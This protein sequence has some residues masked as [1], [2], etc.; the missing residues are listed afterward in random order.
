MQKVTDK[1]LDNKFKQAFDKMEINPSKDLFAKIGEDIH[2]KKNKRISFYVAAASIAVI[3]AIV[4]IGEMQST[5]LDVTTK[6]T[7]NLTQKGNKVNHNQGLPKNN[8]ITDAT[9]TAKTNED[10]HIKRVEKKAVEKALPKPEIKHYNENVAVIKKQKPEISG[11]KNIGIQQNIQNNKK[12][13]DKVA[14]AQTKEVESPITIE[15]TNKQS[16]LSINETLSN[17][18]N[19][20]KTLAI[21]GV[22]ADIQF[23]NR[24]HKFLTGLFRNLKQ[25]VTDITSEVVSSNSDSTT[26]DLG[27]VAITKYKN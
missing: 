10:N 26:V 21:S 17:A 25:K 22:E 7:M 15:K 14:L 23:Q 12:V 24:K 20:N 16:D 1:D 9:L 5:Q 27:F 4:F 2:H 8:I 3:L 19:N 6:M 11:D 13:N 18:N